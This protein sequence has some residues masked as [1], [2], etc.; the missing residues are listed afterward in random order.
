MDSTLS[1]CSICM[2]DFP[3]SEMVQLCASSI[4]KHYACTTCH[5]HWQKKCLSEGKMPSCPYC[6]DPTLCCVVCFKNDSLKNF[7]CPC[8][9]NKH[10]YCRDCLETGIQAHNIYEKDTPC[11][12]CHEVIHTYKKSFGPPLPPSIIEARKNKLTALTT[13][14][15]TLFTSTMNSEILDRTNDEVPMDYIFIYQELL[16]IAAHILTP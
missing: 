4:T 8:S 7:I 1:E 15:D 14:R 11:V 10:Y 3:E 2:S 16:L 9:C 6:R 13:A 5:D 12:I